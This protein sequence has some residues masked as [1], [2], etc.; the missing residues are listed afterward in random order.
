MRFTYPSW[1]KKAVQH[2]DDDH[3]RHEVREVCDALGDR[4]ERAVVDLVQQESEQNGSGKPEYQTIESEKKRV[5]QKP[6]KERALHELDEPPD[7]HPLTS[8]KT[9]YDAVSRKGYGDRSDAGDVLEDQQ[10]ENGRKQ[11]QIEGGVLS[12]LWNQRNAAEESVLLASPQL[13]RMLHCTAVQQPTPRF[14]S[15]Q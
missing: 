5:L 15:C 11:Q 6:K 10:T 7:T 1:P 9:V 4:L 13:C 2:A 8:E 3:D 14:R 12:Q